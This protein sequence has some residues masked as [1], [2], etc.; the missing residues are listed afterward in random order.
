MSALRVLAALFD[1]DSSSAEKK[2]EHLSH[3]IDMAKAGFGALASS[4][5]G[6]FSVGAI[7]QFIQG[8]IELG[9]QINDTAE[10]L[11]VSTDALQK[12]Q[13]AAGLAGV[14]SEGAATALQFLNKN[15]GEALGGGAEQAKMFAEL[16]ISLD[17]VKN[18]TKGAA[19]L[20]PD[21]A[22]KFEEAGS[23]AE[24]TALAMKVFGKQGASLV[25]LLKQG[26][27]ELAKLGEE[28]EAL[29]GGIE[30]DAIKQFD[31]AGDEVDKFKFALTGL[32]SRIAVQ[33]LPGVM[34]IAHALQRVAVSA[35]KTVKSTY[36][37]QEGMAVLGIVG[38]AAGLKAAAGWAKFLGIVPKDAG[39]LQ[40][41][42]KL[43]TFG[44]IIAG[45]ALL[46]LAFEDLF[47]FLAGNESV[48]GDLITKFLGVQEAD[49][50]TQGFAK[51]WADLKPIFDA[52]LA[53]F[54]PI[55]DLFK[56]FGDNIIPRIVATLADWLRIGGALVAMMLSLGKAMLQI[57]IGNFKGAVE[58]VTKT[59]SSLFGEK[60]LL[61]QSAL[62]NEVARANAAAT[63]RPE[64]P[65]V[66]RTGSQVSVTRGDTTINV[67]G[68]G[69]PAGVATRVAGFQR[70][71]GQ[72][73]LSQAA[74]ALGIGGDE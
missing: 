55:A 46:F 23:D 49:S 5:V 69:D 48:I 60:G 18:G 12:F 59:A 42:F 36:A 29:G 65:F 14:S 25:P 68:T 57:S 9:S 73:D 52:D 10:K 56:G 51:T 43:G 54:E 21:I 6:A 32:K 11:G 16:G 53:A 66:E 64:L 38:A 71:L 7:S 13:F 63:I 40:S 41:I 27:G 26:S 22:Q 31:E 15:L 61:T 19:D 39:F 8:Q 20:L 44:L 74:A 45:V 28:F 58:T 3:S 17:D 4:L 1:V 72:S 37:V 50:L 67:N 24:R 33:F 34:S 47:N 30:A 2:I 70:G 62:G 35:Q